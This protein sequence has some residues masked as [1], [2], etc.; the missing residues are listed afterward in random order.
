M[1]SLTRMMKVS[2]VSYF[3]L[4]MIV[5]AF[6]LIYQQSEVSSVHSNIFF[7]LSLLLLPLFDKIFEMLRDIFSSYTPKNFSEVLLKIGF[8]LLVIF[9]FS[10]SFLSFEIFLIIWVMFALFV[11]LDSRIFFIWA[12]VVFCYIAAYLIF[13]KNAEAE[14]LSIQAY[15]LLIAGVLIQ[16]VQSLK[17][18]NTINP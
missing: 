18:S 5:V 15:Y 16:I 11:S 8:P 4:F 12:L 6:I 13:W 9:L 2:Q 14:I 10:A 7:I 3:F 17:S 1:N